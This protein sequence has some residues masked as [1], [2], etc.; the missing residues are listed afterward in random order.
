M[1][2]SSLFLLVVLGL[3]GGMKAQA[4]TGKELCKQ[5]FD[6][7]RARLSKNPNDAG[8]WQELR[9]C[10]DLLKRWGEAG[11]IASDAIDKKVQ[12]PEP[13]FI[14]GLAHYHTKEYP[15][16]VEEYKEAIRLKDD[17]A[18]FYFQLGLAYLHMNQASDAVAAGVR[19]TELDPA[20]PAYHHQLAFSYFST[21]EDEKCEAAA[22]K[23]IELDKNDVAAY[24]ILSSLY[25]RQGHQAEADKMTEESIHANGRLAAANPFVPD[26]RVAAEE[27][28]QP[29]ELAT[30]PS[31]TEVFLKA[32]WER[33][34]GSAL[35][36]D[37]E[38][39]AS[40]YSVDGDTRDLYRQSFQRMGHQRMKD[41]FSKLGEVSD[42]EI[43]SS[44]ASAT[45][46]CSVT[47]A[48]GTL[49]V[50]QVRFEKNSDHTWRIKSF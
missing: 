13:H 43:A 22:K 6:V 14:L 15:Q 41:V 23:A 45:C 16:A 30:P 42:C 47:G 17:Q 49:L 34:K 33:M 37:V 11:L 44:A 8:A 24:K 50:T 25:A 7:Y 26:K 5:N 1:K 21:H 19:A 39:T 46:S 12:R 9:V 10:T 35:K 36:G 2:R 48:N 31:D 29:F 38:A 32:Q 4:D 3:T 27:I 18:L 40:Y 28:P 20:N